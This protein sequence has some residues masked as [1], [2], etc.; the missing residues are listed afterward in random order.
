MGKKDGSKESI[1]SFNAGNYRSLGTDASDLN[2]H[3]LPKDEGGQ[4]NTEST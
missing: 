3:H 2:F 1:P 4:T